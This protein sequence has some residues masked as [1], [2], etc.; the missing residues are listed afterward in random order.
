MKLIEWQKDFETGILEI[1]HD[2]AHLIDLINGL[3]QQL[4]ENPSKDVACAILGEIDSKIQDHF[5][6]EEKIMRERHYDQYSDHKA[7]HERL[8]K[9]IRDIIDFAAAGAGLDYKDVLIERV[10][11][12]FLV[13]F[14]TKDAR[15]H[16]MVE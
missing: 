9:E 8:L 16:K 14:R 1:D 11:R 15:L 7:D 13:H 6:L 3:A 12:W 2:H 5:T 4:D 10:S